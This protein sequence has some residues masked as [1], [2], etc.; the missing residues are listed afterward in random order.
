MT[1]SQK[2][3]GR[4]K[5]HDHDGELFFPDKVEHS[6]TERKGG[7][8]YTKEKGPCLGKKWKEIKRRGIVS[9]QN[10]P[11]HVHRRRASHRSQHLLFPQAS[12]ELMNQ[13]G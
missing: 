8:S 3:R 10:R 11:G 5:K 6:V 1:I 9:N 7:G 13:N 12:G 2:K 4:E